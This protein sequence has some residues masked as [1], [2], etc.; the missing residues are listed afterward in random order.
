MQHQSKST[1]SPVVAL[2]LEFLPRARRCDGQ[3][4]ALGGDCPFCDDRPGL[5]EPG[6]RR[7]APK[8]VT[9][10]RQEAFQM[11]LNYFLDNYSNRLFRPAS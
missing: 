9:S 5:L 7:C 4:M 10:W 6:V 11:T 1:L 8:V 3:F 2:E